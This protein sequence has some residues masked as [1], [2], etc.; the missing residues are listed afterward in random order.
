MEDYSRNLAELERRFAN[1][2]A[3]RDYLMFLRWPDGFR[4][5]RCGGDQFWPQRITLLQCAGC[6]YQSSVIA[7]RMFQDTHTPLTLWFRAIWYVTSQK[8]GASALGVQRIMGLGSYRTAWA[9]LHKLRCA[10]VRP[11]RDRLQGRVEV[12]ETFVGGEEDGVRGRRRGDKSLIVIAVEVEG[13]RIGRIRLRSIPDA[14]AAS[15]HP[16]IADSVEPGSIIHTDG[17]P[18]YKG[19]EQKGHLCETSVIG[20]QPKDAVKLLPHVHLIVALLKRWLLGTHQGAV[21]RAYLGYYLDEFTFRF[22]RRKS[23]SRGKLFYRLLE[24]AVNTAPAVGAT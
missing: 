15:L 5:A 3:C 21:S 2:E 20:K 1:D 11:G 22:N 23:K 7:G 6:D 10:M 4:C 12:Q 18:G 13:K 9:W 8:N 16:F 14:S 24:Q 17:W 19:L